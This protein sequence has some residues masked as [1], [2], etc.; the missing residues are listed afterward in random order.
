MIELEGRMIAGLDEFM[1]RVG[2]LKVLCSAAANVGASWFRVRREATKQLTR[3]V[4]VPADAVPSVANYLRRKRLC[5]FLEV[6]KNQETQKET[7]RYRY[8]NLVVES[9]DEGLHIVASDGQPE[10]WWQDFCLASPGIPSRVGAITIAAKAG[11]K[12][13]LS[14]ISDWAQF[15]GLI[16]R[17]GEVSPIGRLIV[18]LRSAV[19]DET[20]C[21]NPYIIGMERIAFAF[22]IIGGDI[23]CFSRMAPKLLR[24][25]IP[26]RKAEGAEIFAETVQEIAQE[27]RSARYLSVGRKNKLYENMRDLE[28]AARRRTRELGST[29]TAWHRASSRLETYVDV[30]LLEKGRGGEEER[31]EYAYYPTPALERAVESLNESKDAPDW[32]EQHLASAIF[33]K[34]WSESS[35]DE[36]ELLA[37]L[38]EIASCLARP[39]G[40]LPIDAIAIGLVWRRA[41]RGEPI[42]ISAAREA[43]E[44]LAL[45]RSEIARLSRGGFGER[46]EFVSLDIR[47]L[48]SLIA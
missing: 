47:K 31:F 42:S 35:L 12:T 18:K 41:E 33:G 23:D 2:H 13:G 40:P 4:P 22:T 46:A 30:G 32:L 44:Q 19:V 25:T 9:D 10:I 24:S 15:V 45:S 21:S 27:A 17:V 8:P 28:N 7:G 43:I 39:T 36:G 14:H 1:L 37:D 3:L 16:S 38:P 6:G 5:R 34:E 29:S 48:E 26:I 20:S 11:S